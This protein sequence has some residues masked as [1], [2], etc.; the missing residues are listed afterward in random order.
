MSRTSEVRVGVDIGGTFTDLAIIETE[1]GNL[2]HLKSLTS[3]PDASD[4]VLRALDDAGLNLGSVS[5]FSHGTT[6]AINALLQETGAVTAVIGTRGFGDVLELRRGARTHLLDPLMDTPPLYV[7]RRSRVEVGGRI[8][9]DG[10]VIE[11]L[12]EGEVLA[13]LDILWQ[14]GV[15][16]VAVCLLHS[17][18]NP[19]HEQVIGETIA[20]KFPEMFCT[21]SSALVPEIDEFTR[22]STAVINVYIQPVVARYVAGLDSELRRRGLTVPV[23][24]M[25]SNGGL[26]TADEALAS[27]VRMLE[28]GPAAGAIAAAALARRVDQPNAITFDMGGTTA[29]AAVIEEGLP[30]RTMEFELF[31]SPN[32]PGSGWPL[33]VPMVEISEAGAGGGSLAWIDEV[34]ALRV[35][36]QSAGADPGPVCYGRG[37]TQPTITDANAILGRLVSLVEGSM[38]LDVNAARQAVDTEIAAPLALGV[39]D[40]AAGILEVADAK[41]A[42]VIRRVT[43]ARG[44]DPR[45]FALITFGGAGPLQAAYILVELQMPMAV[46]PPAAGNFS[47]EG[48]LFAD[49]VADTTRTYITHVESAELG[50]LRA[51]YAE[52]EDEIRATMERQGVSKDQ[53]VISRSMEMRYQGQF[54]HINVP[55]PATRVTAK[56]LSS[57]ERLFHEEHSRLYSYQ[58]SAEPTEIVFLRVRGVGEVNRPHRER[59]QE[60]PAEAALVGTRAVYFREAADR[61]ASRVYNRAFLGARATIEGPAV[62]EEATSTTLVPPGF[63]TTVDDLGNLI[64]RQS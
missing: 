32:R 55:V 54:H 59:L 35:G 25:Q 64:L 60:G 20:D 17:Y 43:V 57:V 24:I 39:E 12:D 6:V 56:M 19:E 63:H 3:Y 51:L 7:R 15:E 44:R 14:Q 28:S 49:L 45:D 36:P 34:G 13:A 10:T 61:L 38:L 5:F 2:R 8:A 9:W 58:A 31:Q 30:V 46:I 47:A 26:M 52:M 53:V 40:A 23:H 22:T 33:R 42:D 48:L 1:P 11:P 18:I 29:K 27:P 16:A 37:G 62:I 41:A 4:G 50:L 21:I